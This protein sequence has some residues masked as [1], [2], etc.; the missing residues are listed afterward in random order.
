MEKH[1]TY[2]IKFKLKAVDVA[3][4]KSIAAREIGIKHLSSNNIIFDECT[5]MQVVLMF[6]SFVLTQLFANK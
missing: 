2:D 6:L 5:S 4:K 1:R 3:K